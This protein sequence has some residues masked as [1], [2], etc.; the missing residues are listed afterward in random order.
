VDDVDE[1]WPG[2]PTRENGGAAVR[3]RKMWAATALFSLF[4]VE[5]SGVCPSPQ[6]KFTEKKIWREVT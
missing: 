2:A 3:R 4:G 5:R 6:E 1:Q